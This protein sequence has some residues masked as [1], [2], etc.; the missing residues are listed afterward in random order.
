MSVSENTTASTTQYLPNEE[1]LQKNIARRNRQAKFWEYVFLASIILAIVSLLMLFF[2]IIR[3]TFSYVV[4]YNQVN[5]DTLADKPLEELSSD[6]LT[7]VIITF[8]Q[9]DA[10]DL[11]TLVFNEVLGLSS[12]DQQAIRD[13]ERAKETVTVKEIAGDKNKEYPAESAEKS[14]IRLTVPEYAQF[15]QLN[16]D[17]DALYDFVVEYVVQPLI[18]GSWPLDEYLLDRDSIDADIIQI[19]DQLREIN[20]DPSIEVSEPKLRSWLQWHLIVD[21]IDLSRP[22]DAGLRTAILGSLMMISITILVALPLGVG[23]AIYLEEYAQGGWMERLIQTNIDNLAGVPSIIYGILGLALFVRILDDITQGRTILSAAL[24]MALLILPVIIINAQEAIRSVPD[25][26][27]QA[28]YGIGSTKWQTV[29]NHVLPNA[30]PGILTGTILAISR[31]FGETAVLVVV[32]S[33]TRITV[34]PS[35]PLSRYTV[36]PLQIYALITQPQ[37]QFRNVAAAGILLLLAIL[38]SLNA[39]A[40]ILRNRFSKRAV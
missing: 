13:R 26:L 34:D 24:T 1:Q 7:A 29:W 11:R 17:D 31:A 38:L 32:G 20:D 33:I 36:L 23:A 8:Y 6:E 10:N 22:E 37:A 2:S 27:R 9:S 19:E 21:T 4:V 30:M 39:A 15:I 5:P 14:I 40:V 3:Q 25:S 35:G 18:V 28:S 16:F 12:S